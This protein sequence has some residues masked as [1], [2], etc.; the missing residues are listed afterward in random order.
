M[1]IRIDN[2]VGGIC[3]GVGYVRFRNVVRR[4]GLIVAVPLSI[5]IRRVI[6]FTIPRYPF[7][8][9]DDPVTCDGTTF[10]S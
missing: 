8:G 9:G 1:P 7:G 4:E 3:L 2:Q 10:P 6:L 5:K